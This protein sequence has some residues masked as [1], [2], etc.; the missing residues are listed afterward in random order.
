MSGAPAAATRNVMPHSRAN[1]N[2]ISQVYAMPLLH[3]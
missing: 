3:S 1:R 2:N